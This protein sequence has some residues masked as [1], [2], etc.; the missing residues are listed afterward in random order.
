MC[1]PGGS[2]RRKP[3]A[4]NL[5][6]PNGVH[7]LPGTTRAKVTGFRQPTAS[8]CQ[9]TPFTADGTTCPGGIEFPFFFFSF[10]TN[11]SPRGIFAQ[12]Q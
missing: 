1:L 12:R 8:T 3:P 2:A 7:Q 5:D 10:I 9:A 4:F 11:A 6:T